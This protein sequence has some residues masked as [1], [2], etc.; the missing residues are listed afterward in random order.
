[1]SEVLMIQKTEKEDVFVQVQNWITEYKTTNDIKLKKELK[2]LITV[3]VMPF[4]RKIALGLA[5]RSTDPVDDLIQAGALG[6]IKAI[7]LY[8]I[9]AASKFKTYAT[10]LIT[11]EIKH[12]LRDKAAVIKPPRDIHEL[13]YRINNLLRGIK[14]D[15]SDISA[16]KIAEALCVPIEKVNEVFDVDRRKTVLS[17][18][19]VVVKEDDA[20]ITLLEKIPDENYREV[21]DLYDSKII[22]N[23][24]INKLDERLKETISLIYYEDMTQKQVAEKLNISQMQ[25]SRRLKQAFDELYD[26]ITQKN[27]VRK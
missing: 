10:Y 21:V 25:V 3:A 13:S 24:A 26:I 23:D 12:Y 1:M 17:L 20:Y 11:G 8:D 19:E 2:K 4:V 9:K 16:E 22:L 27:K 15:G 5:R 7:E 6:L 18:D 14:V